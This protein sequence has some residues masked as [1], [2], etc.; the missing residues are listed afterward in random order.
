MRRTSIAVAALF[1]ILALVTT[2][3][4]T[5]HRHRVTV[6]R[7]AAHDKSPPLA[8]LALMG[9]TPSDALDADDVAEA[10]SLALSPT[11]AQATPPT[12]PITVP[13]MTT[14]AGSAAVE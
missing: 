2:R 1:A 8:S 12:T 5:T 14:P 11:N 6:H 7:A 4:R 10:R 3:A 9:A 13:V